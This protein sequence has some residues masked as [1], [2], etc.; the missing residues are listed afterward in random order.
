MT[1]KPKPITEKDIVKAHIE[2]YPLSK[3][4]LVFHVIDV[5]SALRGLR[6]EIKN[7]ED[8]CDWRCKLV[9]ELIDKWF[10][11]KDSTEQLKDV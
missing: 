2:H 1:A 10:S 11:L 4:S 5:L 8:L 7:N 6:E 9:N 3:S